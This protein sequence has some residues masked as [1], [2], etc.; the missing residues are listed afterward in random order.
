MIADLRSPF[1]RALS[2]GTQ[3]DGRSSPTQRL[4]MKLALGVAALIAL[5]P[6]LVASAQSS[7]G[8]AEQLSEQYAAIAGA[9][10]PSVVTL[11][12]EQDGGRLQGFFGRSYPG[13]VR[14]AGSGVIVRGD[15]A[16][17]TN[18]HVVEHATRITVAL[19]DGREARAKLLGADPALDL[20]VVKVDLSNLK[21]ARFGDST[22]V[23]AGEWVLAVGAPFGLRHTVTAGV[24]S[25]IDRMHDHLGVV[26]PF[27]QT[28]ANI[29]PGNSGG[30]LLNLRGEVIGINSA[31]VGDGA[32]IGFSIPGNVVRESS[33]QLLRG[34]GVER[35]HLGLRAQPLEA[36]LAAYFGFRASGGALVHQVDQ[37][38]PAARAGVLPGDIV[39]RYAGQ[40]VK[41]AHDLLLRISRSRPE[42]SVSLELWRAGKA[43]TMSI[44]VAAAA[45]GKL[46]AAQGPV[47][48][49]DPLLGL[50][51]RALTSELREELGY[52]GAGAV[53][54]AQVLPNSPAARVGLRPRQ[55]LL[56]ADLKPV[57]K[58]RDLADAFTDKRML[59]RV[60]DQ[61]G[62]TA[63]VL[64]EP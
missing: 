26:V 13:I 40:P 58:P 10:A 37:D 16:V 23:R 48:A 35:G 7:A 1:A 59:L 41:D 44:A 4:N 28:D 42:E 45:P 64:L 5:A 38:G 53:M 46:V 54:V 11:L 51:V 31:Y 36:R 14:G 56:E 8:P 18:Y 9:M 22:R 55:V 39:A 30:P 61:E 47:A 27:L 15:G 17:V 32:G 29:N 62:E 12:V 60:E 21:P 52:S 24:I 6:A 34:T 49:P 63:Y 20:A 2:V 33:E 43:R 3:A 57:A 25:A 50:R 19:Q